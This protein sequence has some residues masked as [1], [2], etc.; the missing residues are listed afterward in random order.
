MPDVLLDDLGELVLPT[1]V[2]RGVAAVEQR[3]LLRVQVWRGEWIED[4][5]FGV[6]YAEWLN[7]K[8]LEEIRAAVVAEIAAIPGVVRVAGSQVEIDDTID[9]VAFRATLFLRDPESGEE[10]V[11]TL[12][13]GIGAGAS[14]VLIQPFTSRGIIP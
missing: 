10:G 14:R 8:P 3:I 5:L 11:V 1:Q 9:A 6:P 4:N 7:D 13:A 12:G 2:V